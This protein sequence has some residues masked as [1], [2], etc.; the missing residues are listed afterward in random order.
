MPI[1]RALAL[2]LSAICVF[3]ESLPR[4]LTVDL[5]ARDAH[6]LAVM[7][8]R[9]SELQIRD[10]GKVCPVVHVRAATAT[11]GISYA[12]AVLVDEFNAPD[13][14]G[15]AKWDAIVGAIRKLRTTAHVYLSC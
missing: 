6:G 14:L 7:D 2:G 9:P 15:P 10:A 8:L 3:A 4:L 11:D 5:T 12:I 1:L 13:K